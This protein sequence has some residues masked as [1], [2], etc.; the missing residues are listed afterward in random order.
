M[1][2]SHLSCCPGT[3][4]LQFLCERILVTIFKIVHVCNTRSFNIL[5]LFLVNV[6]L[7]CSECVTIPVH[8]QVEE[9]KGGMADLT[10]TCARLS[11]DR[12]AVQELL[13]DHNIPWPEEASAAHTSEILGL[14]SR[15]R[16]LH[17]IIQQMRAELEQLSDLAEQREKEHEEERRKTE[18]EKEEVPLPSVNYVAY[19]E[20]DVCKLKAEIRQMS[21]RL[22]LA[23]KPP[24]P[25][26][27]LRGSSDA[28]P[29]RGVAGVVSSS[30]KNKQQQQQQ[31]H[32]G[33]LAVLTNT[34]A[35]LQKH[36]AELENACKDWKKKHDLLQE[37]LRD[38]KEMV[39]R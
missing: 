20:K 21:E 19:L 2:S 39:S 11:G 3:K 31:Q 18:E 10:I 12:A 34:I 38:E 8:C 4:R 17:G 25:S 1:R 35:Q 22:A 24:T 36:N 9:L 5:Q 16:E 37:K 13:R 26:K 15:N 29:G 28:A 14:Q 27:G 32:L 6:L 7:T 23:S 33:Q 30:G